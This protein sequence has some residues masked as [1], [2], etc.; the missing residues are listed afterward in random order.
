VD[1]LLGEHIA[2]EQI[3]AGFDRLASGSA[4]RQVVML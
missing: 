3:N 1:A 4:V 2:L